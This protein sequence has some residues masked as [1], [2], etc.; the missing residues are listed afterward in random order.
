[1]NVFSHRDFQIF[2]DH[3]HPGSGPPHHITCTSMR[4]LRYS[5]DVWIDLASVVCGHDGI[6]VCTYLVVP[7]RNL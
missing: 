2:D 4:V 5:L 3:T 7:M 6:Y 1:M